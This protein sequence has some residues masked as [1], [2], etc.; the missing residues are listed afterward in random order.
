MSITP[1][2]Q[3]SKLSLRKAVKELAQ[4]TQGH[5]QRLRKR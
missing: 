1:I 4:V 5:R 2:L 3:V